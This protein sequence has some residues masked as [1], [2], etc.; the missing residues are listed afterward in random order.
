MLAAALAS[1]STAAVVTIATGGDTPAA[2]PS[3]AGSTANLAVS[4]TAAD[5]SSVIAKAMA[6]VVTIETSGTSSRAG[7][8]SGVGSGVIVSA[9]GLILT[10]AHVVEGASQLTVDLVDGR[11]L[12]ATVVTADT[13]ADLAV[14]KVDATGLTPATLGD[15][16]AVQVGET[17]YAIGSPLGNYTDSVTS[18]V[19][20][21]INRSI[22]VG[23]ETRGQTNDLKGLLQTDAAINPGN[24]G[25]PLI[26]GSGSVIGLVTAGSS[27]AQGIGFAIPIN[28]AKAMI[29][30]ASA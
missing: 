30:S 20:S 17:V 23:G 19:L 12:P 8:V 29:A 25:G 2:S 22:T 13:T 27:S 11:Q 18:G 16:S 4:S 14:I 21:A 28:A 10:N 7:A 5:A 1:A 3:A 24:S 9:N 6:S 15:S 26:D